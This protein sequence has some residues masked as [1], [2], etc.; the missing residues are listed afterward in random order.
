MTRVGK[1]VL[2]P[3]KSNH[4]A[5]DF[6]RV[7]L[8]SRLDRTGLDDVVS[9]HRFVWRFT[10]WFEQKWV[11]A[12]AS[13]LGEIEG[14]VSTFRCRTNADEVSPNNALLVY[15]NQHV[16]T[17]EYGKEDIEVLCALIKAAKV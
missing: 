5:G 17:T 11:L 2:C 16:K 7:H 3:E 1:A 4:S 6:Q 10:A 15:Q 13:R 14:R 12:Q 8:V 9:Q